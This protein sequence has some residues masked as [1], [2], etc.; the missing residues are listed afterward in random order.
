MDLLG[1]KWSEVYQLSDVD[2]IAL[3]IL[4]LFLEILDKHIPRKFSTKKYGNKEVKLSKTCIDSIKF[5]NSL[6]KK[7]KI[8]DD[9]NDWNIWRKARNKTNDLIRDEKIGGILM[10]I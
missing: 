6:R 4:S 5:R 7:A 3:K 8:S 2:D 10:K 1:Q 9:V